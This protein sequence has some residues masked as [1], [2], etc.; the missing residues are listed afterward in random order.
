MLGEYS[1]ADAAYVQWLRLVPQSHPDR[2]EVLSALELVRELE[3]ERRKFFDL[4][5]REFSPDVVHETGWTDL[6]YAAALNLPRVEEALLDAG[7]DVDAR[8]NRSQE[9]LHG[10]PAVDELGF[11]DSWADYDTANKTPLMLAVMSKAR[12]AAE[13]LVNRGADV[14]AFDLYG[15]TPLSL[16]GRKKAREI[17]TLLIDHGANVPLIYAA[18]ANNR[19]LAQS[20]ID[21]G[22]DANAQDHW[23][24]TPLD[25]ASTQN[26]LDVAEFLIERGADVNAKDDNGFTPLTSAANANAVGAAELLLDHGADIHAQDDFGWSPLH[27]AVTS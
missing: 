16:A 7:V 2:R 10:L 11:G 26:A 1:S 15:N 23:G 8:L 3:A 22:A 19:E 20:L 4:L 9:G 21:R 24:R 5:G 17:A 18:V 13:L 25:Y 12:E 14:N 6:H 27:R